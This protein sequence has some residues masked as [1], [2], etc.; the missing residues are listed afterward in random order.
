MKLTKAKLQKIIKEEIEKAYKHP[1]ARGVQVIRTSRTKRP[2]DP[3]DS[4]DPAA[5]TIDSTYDILD[6]QG[7]KIGFLEYDE[8]FGNLDGELYDRYLPRLQGYRSHGAGP[9]GKLQSFFKSKTGQKWL[10][11]SLRQMQRNKT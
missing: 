5:G 1:L 10:D 3:D 6:Q 2:A 9:L 8:Y 7:N 4:Y 11:V